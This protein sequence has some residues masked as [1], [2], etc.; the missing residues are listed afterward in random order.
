MARIGLDPRNLS[1]ARLL[2]ERI[3]F[4]MHRI[5]NKSQ[6]CNHTF[7][8]MLA[9][10]LIVWSSLAFTGCASIKSFQASPR[11]ICAGDT[12]TVSWQANGQVELS[13]NPTVP[14]TGSKQSNG[15]EKFVL[16]EST[17]FTLNA[18][19]LFSQKTAEADVTVVANAQREFGDLANCA[20]PDGL[21]LS[22]NLQEPQVSSGLNVVSVTNMNA[23]LISLT[24]DNKTVTIAPGQTTTNFEPTS[25]TGLWEVKSALNTNETCDDALGAVHDRLT[26][27]LAFACHE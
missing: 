17:R 10:I 14:G 3:S 16:Q 2:K 21:R 18:E 12:V 26:F 9:T 13:A 5:M 25:A 24:K 23:R 6:V 27:R 15:S 7:R 22:L 19:C 20:S 1:Q 11:N 8:P 4:V